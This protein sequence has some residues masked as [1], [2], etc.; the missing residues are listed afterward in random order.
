MLL[1]SSLPNTVP[2]S[3]LI[4][5]ARAGGV[6]YLENALEADV[7]HPFERVQQVDVE[8][9]VGLR[10]GLLIHRLELRLGHQRRQLLQQAVLLEL[11][12]QPP[13]AEELGVDA[14]GVAYEA[15][16]LRADKG[17]D[18]EVPAAHEQRVD[19]RSACFLVEVAGIGLVVDHD[20]NLVQPLHLQLLAGFGDLP[21]L[22]DDSAQRCLVPVLEVHLLA[23]RGDLHGLLDVLVDRLPAIIHIY[24][25]RDDKDALEA[26]SVLLQD[27]ADEGRA[28]A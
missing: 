27:H 1:P 8:E 3:C 4:C 17:T 9:A 23:V 21:L 7:E 16:L 25:R 13:H 10:D 6:S 24:G 11:V 22:V 19:H 2:S 18:L 20:Q 12:P 15:Q 28:L 14:H 26:A 5:G